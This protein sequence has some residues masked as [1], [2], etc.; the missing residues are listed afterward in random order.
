MNEQIGPCLAA[1]VRK[2]HIL[3]EA[4]S[5][6]DFALIH[7]RGMKPVN[8]FRHMKRRGWVEDANE[9]PRRQYSVDKHQVYGDAQAW[10]AYP[11]RW[12]LTKDG[13][14][15]AESVAQPRQRNDD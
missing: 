14:R 12:R 4:P 8:V 11:Y 2:L 15:A 1:A 5:W 3:G 9:A 6:M 7:R 13:I 10:I